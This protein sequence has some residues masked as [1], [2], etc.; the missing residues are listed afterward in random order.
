MDRYLLPEP[1][2]ATG[3]LP[4]QW[5][6]FKKQFE[7][8]LD[9]SEKAGVSDKAKIA[10]LLRTIGD[11]GNDIFENFAFEANEQPTF[12]DVVA[13]FEQFC[14]P[15]ISVF[16]ARHQFLTMKQNNL[17]I[18]EFLTALKKQVRDCAF[19]DLKDDMVLHALTLGLDND[20]TRRRLFETQKLTLDKAV[21]AALQKIPKPKCAK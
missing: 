19:G 20:R 16:A 13:K 2:P 3:N 21:S 12:D 10:I 9:A 7:Q 4:E 6:R 1:I 14:K 5:A 17:T 15:R 8:F 18:D 11:K